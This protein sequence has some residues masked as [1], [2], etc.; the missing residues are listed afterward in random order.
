MAQYLQLLPKE[1][2]E[3]TLTINSKPQIKWTKNFSSLTLEITTNHTYQYDEKT[4]STDIFMKFDFFIN[5]ILDIDNSIGKLIKGLENIIC[6]DSPEEIKIFISENSYFALHEKASKEAV[7]TSGKA[8]KEAV[9]TSKKEEQIRLGSISTG[10]S[11]IILPEHL[12]KEAAQGFIEQLK[13]NVA[14]NRINIEDLVNSMM[15]PGSMIDANGD[16]N[17]GG[18]MDILKNFMGN[19]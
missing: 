4:I 2:L 12:I 5:F 9:D 6:Y 11:S 17:I 1:L 15:N 13:S 18:M 7:A 19:N 14:E 10:K 16:L 8:S 3:K